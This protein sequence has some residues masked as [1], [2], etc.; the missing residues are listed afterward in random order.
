MIITIIYYVLI[1]YNYYQFDLKDF[2]NELILK[3]DNDNV[4]IINDDKD[5]NMKNFNFNVKIK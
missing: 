1:L 2:N 5:E 3:N 4:I